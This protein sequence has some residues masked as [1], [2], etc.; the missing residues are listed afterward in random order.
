MKDAAT[1]LET[2]VNCPFQPKANLVQ[3]ANAGF[4][5]DEGD[6]VT[7]EIILLHVSLYIMNIKLSHNL[8]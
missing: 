4:Y 1:R 2:L 5:Y 3:L 6:E 8:V 7:A